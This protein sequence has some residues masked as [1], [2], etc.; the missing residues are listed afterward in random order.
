MTSSP[1]VADGKV[2][3]GSE[4]GWV[5]CL[6]ADT[7]AYIWKTN[8]VA[9][10]PPPVV[11]DNKVYI[12]S[13]AGIV[14]CLNADTGDVIWEFTTGFTFTS[15]PVVVEVG[16]ND[17]YKI[18]IGV[19][20]GVFFLYVVESVPVY[21]TEYFVLTGAVTSP[22]AVTDGGIYIG[23]ENWA[24]S[25]F[26]VYT[27]MEWDY[28]AGGALTSPA[29]VDDKVYFGSEDSKVYCLET[30]YGDLIW[31]Y[32]T[33]GAVTSSPAV[34][35][36]KVYISS[37]DGNVYCLGST[38][39]ERI[40]FLETENAARWINFG[41]LPGERINIYSESE[42]NFPADETT[43]VWHGFQSLPWSTLSE[44]QQTEFLT[45]TK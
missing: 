35:D 1:V 6:D 36:G 10:V 19:E 15:S 24:L 2:Y 40:A 8:I 18:Y 7:G 28:V 38:L 31:E 11:V 17:V 37:G 12:G 3:I 41:L 14:Y 32:T 34:A 4:D 23:A 16:F 44:E 5:Y 25:H 42:Y 21:I 22:P 9:A 33:G 45:T 29:V 39:D 26:H 30:V 20:E 43:H 13:S 27:T